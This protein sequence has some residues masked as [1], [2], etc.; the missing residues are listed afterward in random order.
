MQSEIRSL[1]NRLNST[2]RRAL[3]GAAG[4]CVSKSHYNVELEHLLIKLIERENSD[5]YS[6]LRHYELDPQVLL[7]QLHT[8]LDKLPKGN[9]AT[10]SLSA[11]IFR[12]LEESWVVASIALNQTQVRSAAIFLA[13]IDNDSLRGLILETCPLLLRLPRQ[14][15]R[16][17]LGDL[18]ALMPENDESEDVAVAT[19]SNVMSAHQTEDVLESFTQ[20]LTVQAKSGKLDPVYGR[21]QEIRQIID[22]LSRRKQNNPIVV[23]EAGVGKT[24]IVE[25][26]AQR[27]VSGQVPPHLRD[28]Q[29]LAL[30]FVQLQ[31]GASVK[32]QFEERL[33]TLLTTVRNAAKPVILFV[34][35]AHALIGAG[36]APGIGDAAN[37]LKPALARGELKVIAA[38]TWSEYKR[39]FE[40]DAALARRFEVVKVAEPTVPQAVD[41]LRSLSKT[42]AEHHKVL[43][44]DEAIQAAVT[45][46]KRYI[47]GRQLPDKA[48]RI[49]DTA[50]A[51][52]ALLQSTEPEVLQQLAGQQQLLKLE[53]EILLDDPQT[54][55]LQEKRLEEISQ[56][57]CKIDD[58]LLNRQKLWEDQRMIVGQVR[59]LRDQWRAMKEN[60]VTSKERSDLLE[61]FSQLEKVLQ[62]KHDVP[63][64]VDK[65][66]V[67]A[68]IADWTGIPHS[69]ILKN[70]N[71][72]TY[73]GL[74]SSLQ[75]KIC[76]Q[77]A[78]LGAIAQQIINYQAGLTDP[79]KP[80]GVFL[81]TGPTG[82]GKTETAHVLAESLTGHSHNL[83]RFN[84]TEFQES[85]SVSTLKGAPPGYVGY[86]KGGTLT[87]AVRHNPYSV[88]L[89]DEVDKAHRDVL[90]LFYQIFDKG[91]IEDAEGIEV[92]FSNTLILMTSNLGAE[93][94]N[95]HCS[96]LYHGSGQE[97]QHLELIDKMMPELMNHFRSPLLA[98]MVVIPYLP[99]QVSEITRIA[100]QKLDVIRERIRVQHNR[101]LVFSDDTSTFFIQRFQQNL[102]QGARSIDRWINTE[103]LPDL[104]RVLSEN[105]PQASS[106]DRIL[107][108][109]NDTGKWVP[110]LLT[111]LN[112]AKSTP[113][114]V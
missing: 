2:C 87:E 60:E 22:I 38:T 74:L 68:V 66:C 110:I 92:D 80:I 67:A 69:T 23:G 19:C 29:I 25:G 81:L 77:S 61:Q 14:T 36:G 51:R 104:A 94:I 103:I 17:E 34:D 32:G 78:A 44:V 33:N 1:I 91:I 53:R 102:G 35:E 54:A 40:K 55:A 75:E 71:A 45:L 28:V 4:L 112:C 48:I 107:L 8:A 70:Q 98:R 114:V 5:V 99:L 3:E 49:L 27:I 97:P 37:L 113:T 18:L 52:V 105:P 79:R 93:I 39:Y 6:I 58:S 59:E 12:L 57:L 43:I 111:A 65:K 76:G 106:Q 88:I 46:S 95:D 108:Q 84:M 90:D 10:P 47:T 26:L 56:E 85:H 72:M 24:A 50:A 7:K 11:H 31:A 64:S 41:M 30:D 20:N 89:L 16:Q 73:K 86:G 9:T 15:C 83:L 109:L 13:L 82:V 21:E 101:E 100:R 96:P 63:V 42:L 62:V